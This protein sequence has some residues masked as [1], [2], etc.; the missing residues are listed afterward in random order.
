MSMLVGAL[1][2]IVVALGL[3][4]LAGARHDFDAP[5]AAILNRMVML[6]ALPLSL[7]AGVM[8][9]PRKVL[10]ANLSMFAWIA[11]V[12]TGGL[13][14]VYLVS[15]LVARRP[16]P[17]AALQAL[18]IGAPA[19]PFVGSSVLPDLFPA[20]A[21]LAIAIGSL[22]VNI[23]QVPLVML[24]LTR[25]TAPGRRTP[26]RPKAVSVRGGGNQ[27]TGN[28]AAGKMAVSAPPGAG[29]TGAGQ[30][31]AG[32]RAPASAGRSPMAQLGL[33]LRQTLVE[34]VVWAPLAA[35]VL[36]ALG[37]GLPKMLH[38][39]LMLLGQATGGVAL[40]A[41]GATLFAQKVSLSP[42]VWLNVASRNLVIPAV[43]W[44]LMSLSGLGGST[45]S[46]AVVTLAIP[47]ASIATILAIRFNVATREMA[48][49]L[50]L[51]TIASI[52]TMGLFLFLTHA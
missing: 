3:G 25:S 41:S 10:F 36:V 49:T 47:S 39:A 26:A 29:A 27:T 51:S 14:V 18:A 13:V 2:P 35:F 50:F 33:S 37:I 24:V 1:L 15:R 12:M 16:A 31:A 17:V 9:A 48:S 38:G 45:T 22:V 42:T 8:A 4:F 11:G 30:G 52:A 40:F 20:D 44:G 7:F 6:Y 23:V 21:A 34:P 5:Q 43:A 46:L 28:K 32:A 19:V